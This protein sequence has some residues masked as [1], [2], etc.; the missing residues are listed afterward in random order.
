MSGD[1]ARDDV[2]PYFKETQ[3]ARRVKKYRRKVASPKQWQAIFADKQGPCRLC[4]AAGP[5]QMHHL[6]PRD[7]GGDDVAENMIPLCAACHQLVELR[8]PDACL[9]LV[10]STWRDQPDPGDRGGAQD[11]YSYACE[12]AGDDWPETIYRLRYRRPA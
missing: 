11:E 1:L 4:A 8:H 10:I 6:V 12:K 2:Q 7:R 9:A 5:S 3:L